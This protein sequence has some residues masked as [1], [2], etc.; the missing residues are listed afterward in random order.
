MFHLKNDA[1]NVHRF[2]KDARRRD[3]LLRLGYTEETEDDIKGATP[4]VPKKRK[5]KEREQND[6]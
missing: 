5:G 3:A 1:G 2:T 4:Y 6:G